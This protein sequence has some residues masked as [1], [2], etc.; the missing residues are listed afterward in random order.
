MPGPV[1]ELHWQVPGTPEGGTVLA[2]TLPYS[3][4]GSTTVP[5]GPK[6]DPR[7]DPTTRAAPVAILHQD[8][9]NE[10]KKW[11]SEC[12]CRASG[13]GSVLGLHAVTGPSKILGQVLRL[14]V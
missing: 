8:R 9:Q 2:R 5:M 7:L 3:T 14:P 11:R 6:N 13:L 1:Q 12:I 10:K 4:L